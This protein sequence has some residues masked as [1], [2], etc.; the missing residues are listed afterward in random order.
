VSLLPIF[1]LDVVLFPGVPL[2]LHIFEPR[3]K[4]MIGE[5]LEQHA[6]FGIVRVQEEGIAQIGCT[7]EIVAV[8]KKHEDGKLD[9]VTEGRARFE[10]MELNQERSFL[11]GEV[12]YVPDE[13]GRPSNTETQRAIALHQEILR[14]A[15]AQQS[16]DH[17]SDT[18]LSY[19]MAGAL[20]LDADFK[21]SLLAMRSESERIEAIIKYFETVRRAVTARQKASGNGHAH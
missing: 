7:A 4:E 6:P 10:L 8:T 18:P 2:P 15:G 9:I 16:L 21:Q 5:C 17:E 12:L 13:P 1:P 20:P 3:Y 11:R 14:L 19:Q